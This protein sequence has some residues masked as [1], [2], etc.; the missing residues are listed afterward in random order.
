LSIIDFKFKTIYKKIMEPN[1][2]LT[3]TDW[4]IYTGYVSSENNKLIR[5]SAHTKGRLLDV[6]QAVQKQ[7]DSETCSQDTYKKLQEKCKH[8]M[9]RGMGEKGSVKR[10]FKSLIVALLT[11]FLR[12]NIEIEYIRLQNKIDKKLQEVSAVPAGASHEQAL[13]S[14]EAFEREP[15]DVGALD[16]SATGL[17]FTT[18]LLS[19]SG[20]YG[21]AGIAEEVSATAIKS[22][23]IASSEK[24]SPTKAFIA[25]EVEAHLEPYLSGTITLQNEN[26]NRS[27]LIHSLY[28]K[29]KEKFPKSKL[30]KEKVEQIALDAY[31]HKAA[32]EL[33]IRQNQ[34][35]SKEF[36]FIDPDN[37]ST[38]EITQNFYK[39]LIYSVAIDFRELGLSEEA[40]SEKG[41]QTLK[42]IIDDHIRFRSV[43]YP[44]ANDTRK[45]HLALEKNGQRPEKPTLWMKPA[46]KWKAI[47]IPK[48]EGS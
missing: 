6:F 25:S 38:E 2:K 12:G 34:T 30:T 7:L 35:K 48:R 27:S 23:V 16:F 33:N 40:I 14:S 11:P 32:S 26:K 5:S 47:K 36:Q 18:T 22:S 46:P 20:S 43:T 3:L 21:L 24:L 44:E 39:A 17:N 19:G 31:F 41:K 28:P 10:F 9:D 15:A 37:S 45:A 1:S 8:L 42:K 13:H 29:F 4:S